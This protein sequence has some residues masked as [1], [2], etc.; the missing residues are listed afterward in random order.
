MH[1]VRFFN[2]LEFEKR[3]SAHTLKAYRN[4]LGQ[5]TLF[6]TEF[7]DGTE[8]L[9]A[10]HFMIRSW[11]VRL[12]ETETE[13][14]SIQRKISTLRSFYR[15]C[16]KENIITQNPVRK[17]QVPK[18]ASTLP[19]IIDE[20]KM[21][22]LLDGHSFSDDFSGL[23]NHLI[24]EFLYSTGIR[25]SELITVSDDQIDL[26]AHQV[27]VMGKRRKERLIPYPPLLSDLIGRYMELR[28]GLF[29]V[30]SPGNSLFVTDKNL[31]LYPR[32]IYRVVTSALAQ[33][34]SQQKRSPHVLRHSYATSLLDRGADLNAIKELL[35]HASLAATQIYTHN[36]IQRLK[37]V[38]DQAHP[39]A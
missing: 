25:L 16:L 19:A 34:T 39:K 35:G 26:S 13:A 31:C 17:V 5:F 9:S 22:T 32:F 2:Y 20:R 27:K 21:N 3:C 28:D 33:V 36:S 23:R 15:F 37:K 10:D 14:R 6:L 30:A 24:I 11:I 18:A 38:Y 12:M 1:I 7:F 4:D 29:G 8:V